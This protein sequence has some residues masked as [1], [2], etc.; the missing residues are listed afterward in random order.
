MR[1]HSVAVCL[2]GHVP[3]IAIDRPWW[4]IDEEEDWESYCLAR[5]TGTTHRCTS[6]DQWKTL[7]HQQRVQKVQEEAEDVA[8]FSDSRVVAAAAAA[9]ARK[10]SLLRVA[11]QPALNDSR[12]SGWRDDL[13]DERPPHRTRESSTT[14]SSSSSGTRSSSSVATPLEMAM[15]KPLPASTKDE[16]GGHCLESSVVVR[17]RRN[18]RRLPVDLKGFTPLDGQLAKEAKFTSS[19][20]N[21]HTLSQLDTGSIRRNSARVLPP[22]VIKTHVS[23]GT[24][25]TTPSKPVLSPKKLEGY[26][27]FGISGCS[28]PEPVTTATGSGSGSSGEESSGGSQTSPRKKTTTRSEFITR[29]LFWAQS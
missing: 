16:M 18:S 19:S 11:S 13:V 29:G 27:S 1:R 20:S 9:K 21:I 5:E 12:S 6:Y 15:P 26:P 4:V 24:S 25:P 22:L 14:V 10:R 7:R 28:S 3:T 8:R 23:V 2:E 17:K